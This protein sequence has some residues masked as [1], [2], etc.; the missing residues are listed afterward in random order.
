MVVLTDGE[1]RMALVF[2]DAETGG[3]VGGGVD[4]WVFAWVSV[5]GWVFVWV[6]VC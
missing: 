4:G 1:L 3:W 2:L 5:D 6:W